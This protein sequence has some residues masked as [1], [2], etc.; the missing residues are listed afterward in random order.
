[1]AA[2]EAIATTYLEASA[3]TVTFSSLGSYE[4]LQLRISARTDDTDYDMIKVN[5]NGDTAANYARHYMVG[6]SGVTSTGS[7]RDTSYIRFGWIP[8]AGDRA[9][10]YSIQIIDIL[11]YRNTNK[12]TTVGCQ[13]GYP[14]PQ[15]PATYFVSGVWDSA[16]A[17]TSIVLAPY[18]GSN[19]VRGSEFTLYGLN[20]A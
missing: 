7:T 4:H 14:S 15:A 20:S 5:F 19:F 11:D 8:A 10:F 3:A 16:A 6:N 18:Q 1:M 13:L 17:V 9:A 2:I 12:N